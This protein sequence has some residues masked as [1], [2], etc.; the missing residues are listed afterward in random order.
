MRRAFSERIRRMP[1][2]VLTTL[3]FTLAFVL[4]LTQNAYADVIAEGPG[5]R[6]RGDWSWG[7]KELRNVY[8]GVRDLA[9]DGDPVHVQL[10]VYFVDG[11]FTD[12]ILH[13]SHHG[14]C[15]TAGNWHNLYQSFG[16]KIAGVKVQACVNRNFPTADSCYLSEYHNNPLT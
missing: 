5:V 8:L 13:R 16:A 3:A 4:G 10:H 6:G 9:C 7:V 11:T 15:G 12:R 2:R 14:G 1:R